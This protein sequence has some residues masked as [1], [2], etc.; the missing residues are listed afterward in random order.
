MSTTADASREPGLLAGL[1]AIDPAERLP[2]TDGAAAFRASRASDP[3]AFMAIEVPARM[4]PRAASLRALLGAPVPGLLGPLAHGAVA[5]PGR[6]SAGRDPAW[7][8]ICA[9]PPGPSLAAER[10]Q[11]TARELVVDVLRPAASVLARLAERGLTHRG[12]RPDNLFRARPGEP[13]VLGPAWAAPPASRQ[14]ALHEPPYVGI[15]PPSGRGEG[16]IADDVYALGVALLVLALGR[17]P[18]AALDAAAIVQRKL[19]FGSFAAILGEDR[20]PPTIGDLARAMLAEDPAHRPPPS[21]LAEAAFG[22]IGTSA[23]RP[24]RRASEPLV[25]G[26]EEVLEPR[27]LARLLGAMPQQGVRLLRLGAIDRWLRR[28]LG[29]IAVAHRIEEAVTLHEREALEDEA[30]AESFLTMRA[31]AILD[32]LAPLCWRGEWL[33]PDGLGP[34]LAEGNALPALADLVETEAVAS[35]AACRSGR[36]DAMLA[37]RQARHHRML[38]RYPGWAGGLARL[39][40]GLNPML[41]CRS[42]LVGGRKLID[43]RSLLPALDAAAAERTETEAPLPM[44]AETAAFILVHTGANLEA[45][46]AS[47]AHGP[48][49]PVLTVLRVLARLQES[50]RPGPLPGLARVLGGRLASALSA[51]RE[52]RRRAALHERLAVLIAQGD[53][54]AMLGVLEDPEGRAAD[55]EGMRRAALAVQRIDAELAAI[56][57]AGPARAETARRLGQE[58]AAGIGLV[59]VAGTLAVLALG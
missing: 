10:S 35:W 57:A 33:W 55:A 28:S 45:E 54:V 14:S 51:W 30:R 19:A 47:V 46:L 34:L 41:P 38:L 40:H 13:V 9:A 39:T 21:L 3:G 7:F 48:E 52:R 23:V 16:T 50:L 17:E 8:V 53:L 37:Q 24:P 5:P 58:I 32:P 20:L 1:Y 4:A 44:D 26:A 59:A 18:L 6:D 15:C 43:I 22:R 29:D 12:I 2:V 56:A 11:M 36:A 25:L 31:V 27:S 49:A 42:P